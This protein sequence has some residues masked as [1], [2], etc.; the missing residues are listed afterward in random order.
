MADALTLDP[1]ISALCDD[2]ANWLSM[3]AMSAQCMGVTIAQ[4]IAALMPRIAT[5]YMPAPQRRAVAHRAYCDG[6]R[7]PSR[8]PDP[9]DRARSEAAKMYGPR[10]LLACEVAA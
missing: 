10:P 5:G 3:V 9:A 8:R 6:L 2:A 4:G 7:T 1:E